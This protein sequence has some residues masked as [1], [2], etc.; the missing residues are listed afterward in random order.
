[1][2]QWGGH[3]PRTLILI[4]IYM[5][6]TLYS[7]YLLKHVQN[8]HLTWVSIT[9]EIRSAEKISP[10]SLPCTPCFLLDL[11][12]SPEPHCPYILGFCSSRFSLPAAVF[13]HPQLYKV[14]HNSAQIV[15]SSESSSFPPQ[16][17]GACVRVGGHGGNG[18]GRRRKLAQKDC[19]LILSLKIPW[20]KQSLRNI[21]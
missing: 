1:M 8:C 16:A 6:F 13:H 15:S 19:H 20:N 17:P 10:L 14:K 18:E 5:T 11:S 12:P 7:I 3:Q 4:W 2:G 9:S 21:S